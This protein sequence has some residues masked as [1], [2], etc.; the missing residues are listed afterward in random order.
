M[1]TCIINKIENMNKIS[2]IGMNKL[3]DVIFNKYDRDRN[4]YLDVQELGALL[5]EVFSMAR[6]PITVSQ[7]Q[8]F[9]LMKLIDKNKDG[10]IDRS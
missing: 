1:V 7:T 2:S 3:V 9:M 8:A 4:G 5:T 6:I 10:R